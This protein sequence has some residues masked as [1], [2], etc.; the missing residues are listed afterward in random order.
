VVVW[1]NDM[2]QTILYIIHKRS[3]WL[4]MSEIMFLTMVRISTTEFDSIRCFQG[5][6][7][8]ISTREQLNAKSNHYI[9]MNE[10]IVFCNHLLVENGLIGC[11]KGSSLMSQLIK[12]IIG[13]IGNYIITITLGL[14]KYRQNLF[15][16][17]TNYNPRFL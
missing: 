8:I 5:I 16:L 14:Q 11:K 9:P 2:G 12:Y 13:R 4:S 10:F 7:T 17:K 15:F 6:K 1:I 3:K